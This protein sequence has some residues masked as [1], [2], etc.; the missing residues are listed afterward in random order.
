MFKVTLFVYDNNGDMSSDAVAIT[1]IEAT[2]DDGGG[3]C[4]VGSLK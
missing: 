4:F 1:V 2:S 3:G